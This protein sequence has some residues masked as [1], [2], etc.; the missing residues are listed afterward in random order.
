M[1]GVAGLLET[2][3]VV[4]MKYS[5]GLS[6]LAPTILTVALLIASMYLLSQAVKELP[7]GTAYAVWTGI[8]AVG[9]VI[10]G[11][12]LFDEPSEALRI[13]FIVLVIMG[14]VGLQLTSGTSS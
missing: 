7:M 4:S 10:M 9:A 1:L 5:E 13:F 3:W 14:I 2:G 12:I 6:K 11:I 8:G